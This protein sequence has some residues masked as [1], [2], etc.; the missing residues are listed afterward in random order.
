[1]PSRL[2]VLLSL[3]LCMVVPAKGQG[4]ASLALVTV[5]SGNEVPK[6]I[7][8]LPSE[9]DPNSEFAMTPTE[10][11]KTLAAIAV[12][13]TRFDRDAPDFS[14]MDTAFAKA[15]VIGV[16]QNTHGTKELFQ[17]QA[18]LIEHLIDKQ[19]VRAVFLEDNMANA[20]VLNGFVHDK[21]VEKMEDFFDGR[22]A[23]GWAKTTPVTSSIWQN[24]DYLDLFVWIR[25]WNRLHPK[26][27]VGVFGLDP[28]YPWVTATIL[29]QALPQGERVRF[30]GLAEG[31]AKL[32]AAQALVMQGGAVAPAEVA[33]VDACLAGASRLAAACDEAV[34]GGHSNLDAQTIALA[35]AA[36]KSGIDLTGVSLDSFN[37]CNYIRDL[38]MGTTV[39]K[40]KKICAPTSKVAVFAHSAHLAHNSGNYQTGSPMGF[41]IS[42]DFADTKYCVVS[43]HALNGVVGA[44][45]LQEISSKEMAQTPRKDI[46]RSYRFTTGGPDTLESLLVAANST[47]DC[48]F[49]TGDSRFELKTRIPYAFFGAGIWDG[50]KLEDYQDQVRPCESWDF[51]I[52]LRD[53]SPTKLGID[54][55]VLVGLDSDLNVGVKRP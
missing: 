15:E 49:R 35:V 11:Q 28:Q 29:I 21:P 19:N 52:G 24:L 8:D 45:S 5:M 30:D 41:Y 38:R 26:D 6:G 44:S 37:Q 4:L 16:G 39:A 47:R 50:A 18:Q 14:P 36:L 54:R 7:R 3:G 2:V 9:T 51:L 34:T 43:C 20:L 22:I 1:M 42:Q 23:I 31:L 25:A 10:H 13:S 48:L 46:W 12:H 17:L 33:N 27:Q 53:T 32:R 40:L 55:N